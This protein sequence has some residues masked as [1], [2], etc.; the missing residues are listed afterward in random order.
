MKTKS[1]ILIGC[2][3]ACVVCPAAFAQ[4][5]HPE[6]DIFFGYSVLGTA[7]FDDINR[8]SRDWR[9]ELRDEGYRVTLNRSGLLKKGFI[10]TYTYNITSGVGLDASFRY[11]VG[12]ILSVSG[13]ESDRGVVFRRK[14]VEYKRNDF[15]FLAGPR[16]T[17]R[18]GSR[19]IEPFVY[20]LA[21][22]SRDR[23]KEIVS[24]TDGQPGSGTENLRSH[25]S[26][27]FAGGIGLDIPVNNNWTVRAIQADY[28]A[29]SH[30]ARLFVN[31]DELDRR[32]GNIN[33]SFGIV[34]RFNN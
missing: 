16:Y 22:L 19:R 11:N 18:N 4:N 13:T 24:G 25:R 1:L 6:F 3:M 27:A 26:F 8:V 9:N 15:A 29:T 30:P 31:P 34:Y 32:F 21:G 5:A 12:A 20:G 10:M 23:V 2:L 33:V 17:F 14:D 7:E 28:Y